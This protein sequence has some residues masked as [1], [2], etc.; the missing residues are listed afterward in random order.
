MRVGSANAVIFVGSQDGKVYAL[1]AEK[2]TEVWSTPLTPPG[3]EV[4]A[5]PSGMFTA[6][7]GGTRDYILVG[8]RHSSDPNE[9][10]AL[11]VG[12]GVP[13]GSPWPIDEAD[14][15]GRIGI[16]PMQATLDYGSKRLFFTSYE[17]DGSNRNTVW[18]VNIETGDVLWAQPHGSIATSPVFRKTG[19]DDRLYV[20]MT[21]GRVLAL[22]AGDGALVWTYTPAPLDG[23]VKALVMADRLGTGLF[24]STTNNVYA[25]S[26]A[27][28]T[29]A[30]RW[31]RELATAI[32]NPS[33]PVFL[34]G[35]THV[36]LGS[37]DGNVYRLDAATGN[38]LLTFPL[39]DL[40][41]VVGSPTLDVRQGFLYVGTEAGIVYAIRLP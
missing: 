15:F 36:Y 29:Y 32:P 12:G 16:I 24:F 31:K 40:G 39:G 23:A 41:A 1:D 22:D 6:F 8:T 9:F 13:V 2:G 38:T 11:T 4:Q 3:S 21:D 14:G 27:G 17:F 33:M 37:G 35:T 5:P 34:T 18:C 7:A 20:G 25:I 28:L 26:D 30:P 19:A 10:H